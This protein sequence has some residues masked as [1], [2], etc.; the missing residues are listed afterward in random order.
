MK[1]APSCSKQIVNLGENAR[2]GEIDV[3]IVLP[4]GSEK[5]SFR[6]NFAGLF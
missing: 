5:N 4:F 1:I 2:I 6:L 3:S